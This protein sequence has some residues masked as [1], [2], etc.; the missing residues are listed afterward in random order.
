MTIQII[1]VTALREALGGVSEMTI[2]RW[3]KDPALNFPKPIYISKRRYWR[4]ED[5]LAWLE[6]QA[7]I[8]A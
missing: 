8:E 3:L 2:W 1:A 6:S 5:V 7:E 4:Y